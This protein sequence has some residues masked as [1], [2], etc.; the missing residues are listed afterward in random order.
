L[1]GRGNDAAGFG[2]DT[3]LVVFVD[4]KAE[5]ELPF[6]SAGVRRV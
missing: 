2:K 1:S 3:P 4:A 5:G 6:L